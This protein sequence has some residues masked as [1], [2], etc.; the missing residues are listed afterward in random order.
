MRFALRA[1][2]CR[3]LRARLAMF[4]FAPATF[5]EPRLTT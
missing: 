4:N 3:A 5:V 1:I 2:P